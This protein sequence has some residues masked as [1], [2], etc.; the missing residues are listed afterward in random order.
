MKKDA[1]YY[2]SKGF[3][4]PMAEYFA[5]GR[6]RITAVAPNRD[7]TLTLDFDNGERR[8]Y[9]CKPLL[10]PGTVFAPFMLFDN[11]RRVYLDKDHC[12]SWDIDPAVDSETVW[13]NKVDISP[14][15][16]YVDSIPL[17]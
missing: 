7:F 12:V 2:L 3:D 1:A 8:L 13:S 17:A 11:F 5:A 15:S 10:Q 6:R 16:C 4:L 14:D 9:D